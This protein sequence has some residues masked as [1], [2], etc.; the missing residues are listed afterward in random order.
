[1]VSIIVPKRSLN[2]WPWL[3]KRNIL[4]S[5]L[6]IKGL[7]E[8]TVIA[9]LREAAN[10]VEEIKSILLANYPLTRVQLDAM[11]TYVGHKGGKADIPKRLIG[12]V[13]G[14][15]TAIEIDARLRG[16]KAIGKNEDEVAQ[17]MMS[18]IKDRSNPI[19]PPAIASDGCDSYPEA[20]LETGG[21]VPE[22]SGWERPPTHKQPPPEW[23]CLQVTKHRSGGRLMG[24]TYRVVYGDRTEVPDLMGLNTAY[25]ERTNL[26][27]RQMNGRMVRK[28]LS[29]SKE[30][31]M[32]GA[33]CA[34]E[35]WVYNLTRCSSRH[36]ILVRLISAANALA[37]SWSPS[38]S[39][40]AII[41]PS[42]ALV[43]GLLG[44]AEQGL[45]D[46]VT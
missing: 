12:A 2:A 15:G 42:L 28:T 3:L 14:G 19:E 27:S 37:I 34:W 6:R 9:W 40:R 17:A 45:V 13:S 22:Y 4:A 16:G 43:M 5:I 24:I 26:T 35:D 25:V 31:E 7:K 10:H 32:L 30:E 8:E 38:S 29:F 33:S 46:S 18:Q 36:Q 1:M 41:S 23:K 11:W 39:S 20:M 21:K 44:T